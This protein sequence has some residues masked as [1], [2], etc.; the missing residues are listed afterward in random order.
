MGAESVYLGWRPSDELLG[1][2]VLLEGLGR[3]AEAEAMRKL[4]GADN[5]AQVA[6]FERMREQ[7][8][9]DPMGIC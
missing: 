4:A 7:R 3:T 5:Q 2:A 8:L 9:G 1:Y 6:H